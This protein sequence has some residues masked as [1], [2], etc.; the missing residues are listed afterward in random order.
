MFPW[1]HKSFYSFTHLPIHLFTIRPSIYPPIHPSTY[2]PIHP[3]T[4]SPIY[5]STRPLIHPS[6]YLEFLLIF[7]FSLQRLALKELKVLVKDV[8]DELPSFS[9]S[10]YSEVVSMTEK[11]GRAIL[12]VSF[13]MRLYFVQ[14]IKKN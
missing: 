2:P 10:I 8:N 3:S 4:R 1:I 9:E 5:P 6:V 7:F 12:N 14:V 13:S 11:P